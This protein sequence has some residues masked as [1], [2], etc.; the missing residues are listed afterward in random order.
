MVQAQPLVDRGLHDNIMLRR[1]PVGQELCLGSVW[2]LQLG[3]HCISL[4][5]LTWQQQRHL[6]KF[7]SVTSEPLK[8]KRN[9]LTMY[10]Y[11]FFEDTICHLLYN[12]LTYQDSILCLSMPFLSK[13]AYNTLLMAIH[14]REKKRRKKKC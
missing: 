14:F 2:S 7:Y 4:L 11:L 6:P 3:G 5:S 9:F 1:R 8:V 13:D 10:S 12:F